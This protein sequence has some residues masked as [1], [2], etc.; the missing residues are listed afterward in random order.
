MKVTLNTIFIKL[1]ILFDK[2]NIKAKLEK[3]N[4][5]SQKFYLSKNN[6]FIFI[7]KNYILQIE[8]LQSQAKIIILCPML[9]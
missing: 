8:F 3:Y 4:S 6:Y 1:D 9:K 7:L 2:W 5:C